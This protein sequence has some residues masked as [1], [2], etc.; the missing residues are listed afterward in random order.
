M[1]NEEQTEDIVQRALNKMMPP[2]VDTEKKMEEL[3]R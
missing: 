1:E 2:E 3:L